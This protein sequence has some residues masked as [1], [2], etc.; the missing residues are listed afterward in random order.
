MTTPLATRPQGQLVRTCSIWRALEAVG[1]TASLLILESAWL[2][3]RRFDAICSHTGLQR[4][5]ASDRLKRLVETG[6]FARRAYSVHPPRFEY[7]LTD[8]GLALF[9]TALM[10]L[11]WEMRW[12]SRERKISVRLH[13]TTCDQDFQPVQACGDCLAPYRTSQVRWAA[14]PGLGWMR[15]LA[16]RRRQRRDQSRDSETILFDT[17]AQIAGD[18]WSGLILRSLFMGLS[19]FEEI[20]QDSLMASNILADRLDWLNRMGVIERHRTRGGARRDRFR[21]TRAGLDY[22]PVLLTLMQW[23]DTWYAAPEGAP[24]L[25]WHADTGHALRPIAACSACGG[26]VRPEEVRFSLDLPPETLLS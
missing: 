12:G 26:R 16:S 14:G 5:L 20:R 18:R 2:G 10:M 25:L 17:V 19:R 8:K 11:R 21:L 9:D 6:I 24:L 23:G 4:A 3:I 1:D 13:H 22:L 7:V 15:P